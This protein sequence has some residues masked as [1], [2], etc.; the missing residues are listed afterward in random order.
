MD[1][2]AVKQIAQNRKAYHDYFILE[3][4][5]AGIELV[6]TEVKSIRQGHANLKDS[7][8]TIKDGQ[9]TVHGLHISPYEK[10][11]IF[12]RDPIRPRRLLMHKREILKLYARIKQDGVTL[13]P[14][15]LY[16]RR[17]HIKLELGL[18]KGKKLYDKRAAAATK[19]AR[20]EMDRAMKQRVC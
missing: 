5:E 7:Y 17:A 9:L 20:R 6:G 13:I 4:F 18:A 1:K 16:F 19:D 15:A 11:N 8:C 2:K 10:G 12:N 3:K 14:L